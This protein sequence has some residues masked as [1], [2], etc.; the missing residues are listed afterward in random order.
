MRYGLWLLADIA[1]EVSMFVSPVST[2]Y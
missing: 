2:I 1:V